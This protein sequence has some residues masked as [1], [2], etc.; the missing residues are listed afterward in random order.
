MGY[1]QRPSCKSTPWRSERS[2]FTV[3]KRSLQKEPIELNNIDLK[4]AC[5]AATF[6]RQLPSRL[7]S[8]ST[9]ICGVTL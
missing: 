5:T 9:H 2:R 7:H 8:S 1:A 4:G 6:L 3:T